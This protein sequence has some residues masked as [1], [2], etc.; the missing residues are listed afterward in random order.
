MS[1]RILRWEVPVDDKPHRVP[2][3]I[4]HVASR[5]PHVV[6]VWTTP[7]NTPDVMV[8]VVGTGQP[9]PDGWTWLGT[10]L[11]PGGLVWHLMQVRAL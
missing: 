4:A 10:A 1:G 2:S 9:Y 3:G 6:E 5:N 7:T 8:Q 11:A